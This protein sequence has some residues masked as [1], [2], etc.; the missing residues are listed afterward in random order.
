MKESTFLKAAKAVCHPSSVF[1]LLVGALLIY[2][3]DRSRANLGDTAFLASITVLVFLLPAAGLVGTQ[4][5]GVANEAVRLVMDEQDTAGGSA[6]LSR[7]PEATLG[8]ILKAAKPLQRGFTYTLLAVLMSA[9]ALVHTKEAIG[10]VHIDRILSTASLALLLGT[11]VSAFPITWRLMQFEEVQTVHTTLKG[12]TGGTADLPPTSTPAS[13]RPRNGMGVAALVLGAASLVAAL[14]FILFPLGLLGGLVAAVLGVIA[15]TR[16]RRK[17]STNSRQA[18]A[19][20]V[21]GALALAVAIVFSVRF[22][23]FV[24]RNPNVFTTFGNCIGRA[25]NRSAVSSCIARLANGVR[26]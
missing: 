1:V 2:L 16:R 18:V 4:L 3:A 15:V 14:S 24:A 11:A 5:F 13:A 23:T 26:R 25:G 6:Q 7:I 20:I 9:V 12:L 17:G 8:G 21:C 19:G 22:G 10:D